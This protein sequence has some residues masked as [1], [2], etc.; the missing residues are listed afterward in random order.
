MP[1]VTPGLL[2]S[3]EIEIKNRNSGKKRPKTMA[4]L[5]DRSFSSLL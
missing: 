2:P 5:A 1:N 3:E 4:K